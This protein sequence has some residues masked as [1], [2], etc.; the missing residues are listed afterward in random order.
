MDF[1]ILGPLEVVRGDQT[2][3]LGSGR[4]L[5]LFAV[6]L[7]HRNEAIS[8]DRIVD[9]LWGESPP[10][11]AAK[12]VRNS[13][14]LLRKAL[15][16]GGELIRTQ[17]QGYK[18]LLPPDTLDADRFELLLR[19]GRHALA[20]GDAER[21]RGLLGE[22]LALW[23]GPA[24][25]DFAYEPFAQREIDRL[26]ELRLSALEERLEADLRLGR[27]AE[28]VAELAPLVREHP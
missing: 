24:L 26:D 14:S 4:Q 1:R 12:I 2:L 7:L 18:L 11:T 9:H 19:D 23:R 6:L 17:G 20:D 27:H 21:A 16:D 15:G 8:I 25:A 28:L 22:A 10:P 5:A 3:R 13:V